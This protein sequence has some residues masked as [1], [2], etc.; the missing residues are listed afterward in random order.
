MDPASL[1]GAFTPRPDA[2]IASAA[3]Y[4]RH[5]KGDSSETDRQGY[6]NLVDAAK[7]A[8][9]PRFV[10]ISILECDRATE[11]PHFHDKF[12]IEQ[13]LA[14]KR[15]PY[16]ALRPGA[17][18]D[19]AQDFLTPGLKKGEYRAFVQHVPFG[20]VY[21]P[22]LAGYA[23]AAAIDVPDSFL[24]SAID[25][26]WDKT[27]R[28]EEIAAG[29]SRVLNRPIHDTAGLPPLLRKVVFPVV[30]MFAEPAR[31]MLAMVR[32]IEAGHYVSRNPERQTQAFGAPPGL[33][34]VLRRFCVDRGLLPGA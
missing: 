25:I 16:I 23:A 3:G 32:W 19:Q 4:T 27:Y 5:S 15:Q 28:S 33:D 20:Q 11:V 24:N 2:V 12:L 17:F 22:D 30:A 13:Y 8:D 34:D 31:D 9:V 7:A 29:F 18:L 10:L 14:E 21:T 6:R 26:G 1:K